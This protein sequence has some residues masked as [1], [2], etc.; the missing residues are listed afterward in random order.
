MSE[1]VLFHLIFTEQV[2]PVGTYDPGTYWWFKHIREKES[3]QNSPVSR[4]SAERFCAVSGIMKFWS[5]P[6]NPRPIHSCPNTIQMQLCLRVECMK[7][8]SSVYFK[9]IKQVFRYKRTLSNFFPTVSVS[10]IKMYYLKDLPSVICDALQLHLNT[11]T[12]FSSFE[13]IFSVN[14]SI[15]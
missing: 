14:F 9:C 3:K 8:G 2:V 13:E 15:P 4:G 7:L 6:K 10:L 11:L 1:Q 5:K 12:Q